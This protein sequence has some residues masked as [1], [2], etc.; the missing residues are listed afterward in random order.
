[1]PKV[2]INYYSDIL[3]IWAYAADRRIVQLAETFAD[4]VSIDVHYCSIFPDAWNKIET[5]WRDKGGFEGFSKHLNEVAKR[6]PH[7]E[8]HNRLWVDVRP[9][10]SAS[11]HMF[12]KSIQL[13]ETQEGKTLPYLERASTKAAQA[14]RHDF[15]A[16]AKDI[17]DWQVHRQV[18]EKLGLDYQAIDEHI[19]SSQAIAQ[20]ASDYSLS[21]KNGVNVSPT[22]IMNDGRQKLF[23]NVGYRLL[24][25]NVQ[26]L[27]R[28]NSPDE[29][30][31]C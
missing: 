24:E 5:N 18:A 7:V 6:F 27:L 14:L 25:A 26:E 20:L 10:T 1:M 12:L 8:V 23:G 29:A 19:K 15:F 4:E 21:Q 13:L 11:A 31:W 2:Q 17:S 9:R 30:S 22:I 28:T 16:E 3:C